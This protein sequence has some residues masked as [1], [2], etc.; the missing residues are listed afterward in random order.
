MRKE[1]YAGGSAV[2]ST[3]VPSTCL[4]ESISEDY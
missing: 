2:Q 3:T 1:R 4:R